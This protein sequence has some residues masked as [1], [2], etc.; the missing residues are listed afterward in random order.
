MQASFVE[1]V[2]GV[3]L[4]DMARAVEQLGRPPRTHR[5][6]QIQAIERTQTGV[7]R[8]FSGFEHVSMSYPFLDRR[9]IEFCLAAPGDLKVHDG[10]TRY[11]VRAALEGLLPPAIQWRTTKEPF[12]PDFHLRYNRQRP[13]AF[14]RLSNIPSHDPVR[15]IVDVDQLARLAAVDMEGNRG[16][17]PADFAAMHLVPLGCKLIAFLRRFS[18]YVR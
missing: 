2:L 13:S 7:G 16:K 17:T 12:S 10:H 3:E 14:S 11:L 4:G 15:E 18:E 5:Q 1:E 9:V 8:G 6:A